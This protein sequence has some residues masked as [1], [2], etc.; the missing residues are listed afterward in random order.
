MNQSASAKVNTLISFYPLL[1]VQPL[2]MPKS[3]A[4][5]DLARTSRGTSNTYMALQRTGGLFDHLS[6]RSS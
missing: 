3:S 1:G 4:S 6:L 5:T 2:S